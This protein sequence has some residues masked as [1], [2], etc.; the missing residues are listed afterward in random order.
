MTV[1][2]HI[3]VVIPVY[4]EAD[5]VADLHRE[6]TASLES[7]GRPY[8]VIFVDDGS[9]DGTLARLVEIEA[10]DPRVRVLRLRRNF[11]QTAAF[12]AGF[13]AARGNIVVTAD[14]DL[15]ND[16]RDVPE[17]LSRLTG[18]VDVV[19]GWRVKRQDPWLTR[20]LPSAVANRLISWA[21]GV[22]LRDYGC[23]LKAFRAEVVKSLRLWGEMHRF[24]P[25]LASERGAGIVEVAVRHHP[26]RRGRSKYGLSRTFRVLLDLVAVKFLLS[27]STQ[28]L[29]MFGVLG[30]GMSLVG[31]GLLGYL[32]TL[33]LLGL[34]SIMAR[35]PLTLFAILLFFTGVQLVTLGLLAELQAR[36]FHE[37][38]NRP[39]YAV[40]E[41]IES[42]DATFTP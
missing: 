1:R 32:G 38:Q 42:A 29:R 10:A 24:L 41:V 21:T 4:D 9:R 33:R 31:G 2:P 25:A 11:G 6:L 20:R 7:H 5:N 27:Y 8:E 22:R 40:R 16:P 26:R 28:P 30:G 14:A 13:S 34:E 35:L 3:S 39:A 18:D 15:Q 19:C 23:S 36:A 12:A 37:T 17:L